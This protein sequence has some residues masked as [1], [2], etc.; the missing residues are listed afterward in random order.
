MDKYSK[1]SFTPIENESLKNVNESVEKYLTLV[2]LP[3]CLYDNIF[4]PFNANAQ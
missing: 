4:I 1:L 2:G 3:F